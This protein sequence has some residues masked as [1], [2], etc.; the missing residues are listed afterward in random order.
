MK[1]FFEAVQIFYEKKKK[2]SG[3]NRL[4]FSLIFEGKSIKFYVLSP[5]KN[6]KSILTASK[7]TWMLCHKVGKFWGHWFSEILSI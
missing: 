6:Q 1:V 4:I 5:Q 7:L 3:G 2:I